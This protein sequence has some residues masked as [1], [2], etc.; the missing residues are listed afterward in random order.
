MYCC[1]YVLFILLM[2]MY[3]AAFVLILVLVFIRKTPV[4]KL[5]IKYF[6]FFHLF[7]FSETSIYFHLFQKRVWINNGR[8]IQ[9]DSKEWKLSKRAS[10]WTQRRVLSESELGIF[11]NFVFR[12]SRVYIR[13]ASLCIIL[14]LHVF[15]FVSCFKFCDFFVFFVF[16]VSQLK[17]F[18]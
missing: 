9:F 10:L 12:V 5:K 3:F 17:N 7:Q 2:V 6:L 8:K 13:L 11:H 16:T 4:S 18:K 14:F 1:E 15:L